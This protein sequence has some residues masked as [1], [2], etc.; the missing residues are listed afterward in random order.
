MHEQQQKETPLW[1]NYLYYGCLLALLIILSVSGIYSREDLAGSRIFFLFYSIG[2]S[3]FEVLLFVSMGWLIKKTCHR[4]IFALF[5]AFTFLGFLL[6]LIDFILDRIMSFSIWE[7]MEFIFDESFDNFLHMLDASG[8]PLWIW[9]CL[10]SLFAAVPLLGIAIFHITEW[11]SKI[12]PIGLGFEKI[13]MTFFCIPVALFFWDYSASNFVHR[14]AHRSFIKALPWKITFLRP[15][16]PTLA[17][18]NPLPS[19]PTEEESL[20]FLTRASHTNLNEGVQDGASALFSLERK[21]DQSDK[22]SPGGNNNDAIDCA[23]SSKQSKKCG[24]AQT[25]I[26]KPNIYLFIVESLRDDAIDSITAPC[27]SAFRERSLHADLSLSNANATQISWFSIFHSEFP[28]YWS[29]VNQQKRMTG[30]P[31]LELL[32]QL[33]YK[34]R[35]YSSAN[36]SYYNMDELLFGQKRLRV[37]SF[38]PF[39]HTPPKEAWETDAQCLDAFAKDVQENPELGEGQCIIFFWDATHFDYSWP[40]DQPPRFAPTASEMN[41]FRAYFSQKNIAAIKNRYKNAVHYIDSL[42]KRFLTLAP[43]VD[44]SLIVFTGDHGEEFFEHGHLFHL[45]ELNDVQTQVPIY[46]QLPKQPSSR[47]A[48]ATHMD[49]FPTLAEALTGA[50]PPASFKGESLLQKRKWPYAIMARYNA[51]RTP[52][53]ICLHNGKHKFIARFSNECNIFESQSLKIHSLRTA[54]EKLVEECKGDLEGWIE[55]E[56]GPGLKKLFSKR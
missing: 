40:K 49:I 35:V 46:F 24:I 17:L 28:Y 4:F 53:E 7:T 13:V 52:C 51:S 36:L 47:P 33:G 22:G 37:E 31:G 34:I 44:E 21:H 41:Y 2:E 8:I 32:R 6:H 18:N 30:A 26:K 56:F 38:Q 48:L 27:L 20:A 42:F 23:D 54:Q 50:P 29:C 16:I 10:F 5:I 3:I 43:K 9:A 55:K 11:F 19:P 1:V 15:N 14:E 45:S 39:L 25:L 12:K